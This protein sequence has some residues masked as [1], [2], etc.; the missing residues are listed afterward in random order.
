MKRK[1]SENECGVIRAGGHMLKSLLAFATSWDL[2]GVYTCQEFET[3]ATL[4]ACLT[5]FHFVRML[6]HSTRLS[7]LQTCCV[8]FTGPCLP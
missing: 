7:V 4:P 2:N 5:P 1:V 8:P 3:L 6:F